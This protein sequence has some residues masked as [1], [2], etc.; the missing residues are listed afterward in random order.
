MS[1]DEI[2]VDSSNTVQAEL[3]FLLKDLESV[4]KRLEE[5]QE[6]FRAN[7][8]DSAIKEKIAEKERFEAEKNNLNSRM[9]GLTLQAD[10]RARLAI[11]RSEVSKKKSEIDVM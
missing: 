6:A 3:K 2:K 9:R 5:S 10:T 7:N 4:Q 1:S 11:K 8:P